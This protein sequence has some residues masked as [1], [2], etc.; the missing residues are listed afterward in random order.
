MHKGD[1]LEAAEKL[2]ARLTQSLHRPWLL[3][4]AADTALLLQ[5]SLVDTLLVFD[6]LPG[7]GSVAARPLALGWPG[8]TGMTFGEWVASPRKRPHMVLLPGYQSAAAGGLTRMPAR[9]GNDLFLAA[10]DLLAAGARTVLVSRW[11][12]GG[13]STV[14]LMEEFVADHQHHPPSGSGSAAESWHRAVDIVSS[15]EP[16][17]EREPRLTQSSEAVLL[18][19]RHPLFWAGAMLVDCGTGD[20]PDPAL[21]AKPAPQAK[22]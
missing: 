12:M 9:P 19:S 20:R 7:D 1:T 6:E 14:H 21:Q 16:D 18:D 5:A 13:R 3:G 10:T 4:H 2:A 22:P 11:P 17:I 15:E 8:R